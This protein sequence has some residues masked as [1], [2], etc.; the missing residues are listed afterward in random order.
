[1]EGLSVLLQHFSQMTLA[2]EELQYRGNI[3]LRGLQSLPV[4]L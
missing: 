2:T 3:T 1:L 4:K